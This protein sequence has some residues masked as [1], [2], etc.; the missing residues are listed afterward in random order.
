MSNYG[1]FTIL[2][3]AG[4]QDAIM[5][6]TNQLRNNL[7][8]IKDY[9]R[10]NRSGE[11]P[12]PELSDI[13]RSHIL[14]VNAHFRPFVTFA[15]EYQRVTPSSS[16]SFGSTAR[17]S[18]PQYGE[19]FHDM[20]AEVN[21]SACSANTAT[22]YLVYADKL[23][24]RLFNKVSY[25]VNGSELDSYGADT[26]I[27]H[28]KFVVTPNKRAGWNRLIGHE[29][30]HL[31]PV[32]A[33]GAVADTTTTTYGTRRMEVVANGL[34]TPK[35]AHGAVTLFM[36]ILLWFCEDVRVSFPSLTVPSGQRDL[37]IELAAVGDC[38]YRQTY[39]NTLTGVVQTLG[40]L[41]VAPTITSMF[42]YVNNIFVHADVHEIY[43]SKVG[44]NLVRVHRT[45]KIPMTSSSLEVKLQNLKW[46]TEF[47]FLGLRP[48]QNSSH[49]KL[50]DKFY[51]VPDVQGGNAAN[52][53]EVPTFTAVNGGP[54]TITPV[55]QQPWLSAPTTST[56]SLAFHS[57]NVFRDFKRDFFSSY[58]PYHF[59]GSHI[60]TPDDSGVL[61]INFCL[62][63]MAFQPNGYINISRAKDVYL[64]V[65]STIIGIANGNTY[66]SGLV[67][68]SNPMLGEVS[69]SATAIN[70]LVVA[71]GTS[72]LRYST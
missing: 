36:P 42:L 55:A 71:D 13:E 28:D 62:F 51:A 24:C 38:I 6:A 68:G 9:N 5:H 19:F 41:D 33:A 37:E 61:M 23:G 53:L 29:N 54:N 58:L 8:K 57:I 70:F 20:V 14:F 52:G 67:A 27:F 72:V 47:M 7:A 32:Q 44:F 43:L 35:S 48:V 63:P 45:Q 16:P 10:R 2:V 34:Q 17:F 40:S 18:I 56:L 30:T 12:T 60:N 50:W 21:I 65:V 64:S 49:P 15:F 3:N 11:D 46:P 66:L 69:V 39:A 59:G 1:V 31:V 25:S 22:E 4:K 26:Q